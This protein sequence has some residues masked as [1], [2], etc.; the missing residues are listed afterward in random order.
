MAKKS[1]S[2]SNDLSYLE[3]EKS[4]VWKSRPDLIYEPLT[5]LTSS[6]F[7]RFDKT[8][9]DNHFPCGKSGDGELLF[10]GKTRA[11]LSSSNR[12]TDQIGS[13]KRSIRKLQ[14]CHN[15]KVFNVDAF[16]VLGFKSSKCLMWT[17][18]NLMNEVKIK[19][20]NFALKLGYD[21]VSDNILYAARTEPNK[22]VSYIG[23]LNTDGHLMIPNNEDI[24]VLKKFE[25][26][27]IK[28]SPNSLKKLCRLKLR[29]LLCN[30]NLKI[31]NLQYLVENSLVTFI[32]YSNVLKCNEQLRPGESLISPNGKYKLSIDKDGRLLY[33][34]NERRDFLFLYDNVES[35]WFTDLKI[36]VCFNN[37]NST[38]F[39]MNFKSMNFMLTDGKMEICDDGLIKVKSPHLESNLVFQFRDDLVMYWNLNLPKFDFVYFLEDK[40]GVKD[41]SGNSSENDDDDGDESDEDSDEDDDT[42]D[43]S[44]DDSDI[45]DSDS[46]SKKTP[47]NHFKSKFKK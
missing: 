24:I 41:S 47:R 44:D 13:V 6:E 25:I 32:K 7:I 46:A 43:E 2:K 38:S 20:P 5:W 11:R 40:K 18:V 12:L 23:K 3:F 21:T 31:N 14:L 37:F 34:L 10:I 39:L 33:Y 4:P 16:S 45:S 26:L 30:E 9:L 15:N 22:S 19:L 17:Q 36:V 27:C 28:A 42:D 8:K 1:K 35:L 29:L